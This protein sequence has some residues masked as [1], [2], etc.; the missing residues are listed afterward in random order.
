VKKTIYSLLVLSIP[1]SSFICLPGAMAEPA[2]RTVL[3]SQLQS[4]SSLEQV[5]VWPGKGMDIDFI[6]TNEKIVKAWLDDPSKFS[7]DFDGCLS[8]S[9]G[10]AGGGQNQCGAR[11][12]HLRQINTPKIPGMT[13]AE[14]TTLT[15]MTNG[16]QGLKRYKFEILAGKGKPKYSAVNIILDEPTFEHEDQHA[17]VEAVEKGLAVAASRQLVAPSLDKKVHEFI[18]LVH[19]GQSIKGAA[20]AAK[21][22]LATILQ[23]AKMGVEQSPALTENPIQAPENKPPAANPATIT[24]AAVR[25]AVMPAPQ[26]MQ[27][28]VD[29]LKKMNAE[30]TMAVQNLKA[31]L[32]KTQAAQARSTIEAKEPVSNVLGPS[33][34][35]AEGKLN[36]KSQLKLPSDISASPLQRLKGLSIPMKDGTSVPASVLLSAQE[37]VLTDRIMREKFGQFISVL[38][39]SGDV[40]EA[41]AQSNLPLNDLQYILSKA[42]VQQA[43]I[44]KV[45]K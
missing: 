4:A 9:S 36:S 27:I 40:N 28:E 25:N 23:L 45:S 21:I 12:A 22:R 10:G 19:S 33:S 31:E 18:A 7:V 8:S 29:S 37:H 13:Y 32:A 6:A 26:A 11:V 39:I 38:T 2:A 1:A 30:L 16:S 41:S 44:S 14:S 34:D 3:N 35:S 24:P 20:D 43:E 5:A 15:L 17:K 42:Q